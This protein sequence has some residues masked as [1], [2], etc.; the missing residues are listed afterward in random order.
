MRRRLSFGATRRRLWLGG[1]RRRPGLHHRGLRRR[2]GRLGRLC[3]FG[4]L[5][6]GDALLQFALDCRNFDRECL[7]PRILRRE[8]G[9]EHRQRIVHG[10]RRRTRPALVQRQRQRRISR[11][12][13]TQ[14]PGAGQ[15]QRKQWQR[16]EQSA[17]PRN[18]SAVG[19]DHRRRS[20]GEHRHMLRGRCGRLGQGRRQQCVCSFL[21]VAPAHDDGSIAD[22]EHEQFRRPARGELQGTADHAHVVAVARAFQRLAKPS[23]IGE[24]GI[25]LCQRG[26][27]FGESEVCD[28]T[29][30]AR[31]GGVPVDRAAV[32]VEL[33]FGQQVGRVVAEAAAHDPADLRRRIVQRLAAYA[34]RAHAAAGGRD[35]RRL[36]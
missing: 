3:H 2:L 11:K 23:D 36:G 22:Q 29:D 27:A 16:G 1:R 9:L 19:R 35:K 26:G 14:Q 6:V 7:G 12:E 33:R 18:R 15:Q 31:P 25:D 20:G 32:L 8:R 13:V 28:L 10:G 4:R 24:S 21:L 17:C 34:E 30:L 5:A